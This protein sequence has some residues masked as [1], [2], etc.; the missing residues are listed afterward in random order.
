[1]ANLSVSKFGVKQLCLLEFLFTT[2]VYLQILTHVAN[3]SY[4][5]QSKFFTILQT[6]KGINFFDKHVD[7]KARIESI[8]LLYKTEWHKHQISTKKQTFG[9]GINRE[10]QKQ[11]KH[12]KIG[13]CYVTTQYIAK[14]KRKQKTI[15]SL[16]SGVTLRTKMRM[17]KHT[18]TKGRI[19]NGNLS[20][21]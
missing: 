20:S 1:V 17:P 2:L 15:V 10:I 7:I 18:K 6:V 19:P 12:Y 11:P 21:P 8:S 3:N 9:F 14:P 13:H 4:P 5:K 16:V